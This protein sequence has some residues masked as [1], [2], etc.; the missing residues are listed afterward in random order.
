[1]GAGGLVAGVAHRLAVKH[2]EGDVNA[3]D[4]LHVVFVGKGLRQKNLPL[5]VLSERLDGIF[6]AELEGDNEIRFQLTGKLPRHHRGVA[7]IGAGCCRRAL[8]AD[9]LRTAAGAAVRLH[10]RALLAPVVAEAGGIPIAAVGGRFL[11]LRG[12][13]FSRLLRCRGPLFFLRVERLD[14]RNVVTRAAVFALQLTGGA[15]KVQRTGTAG[16]L[17]VG[18]LC[19]HRWFHL[20][21]FLTRK[22]PPALRAGAV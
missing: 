21:L 15:H 5:V 16:A 17:I 22:R 3:A 10:V 12:L 2:P 14:L 19:W 13:F 4:L 6:P 1:M 8:I 18:Y 20:F 9:Q 7:A 11:L